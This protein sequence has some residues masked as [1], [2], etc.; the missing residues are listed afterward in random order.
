[1]LFLVSWLALSPVAFFGDFNKAH[2]QISDDGQYR[3]VAYYVLPTTPISLF[4]WAFSSDI[5]LVLYDK[6]GNYLGQSS[7][8]RFTDQ[9]I[10]FGND[11]FFPDEIDGNEK[12]F[13]INGVNDFVEG[14]TIQVNHKRWWSQII[15]IF[16]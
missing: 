5:F 2:E 15:S 7:P 13:S 3:A 9:Y 16:H 1:M 12:S 11:V 10:V 4:Q 8:F 14:Y 6:H